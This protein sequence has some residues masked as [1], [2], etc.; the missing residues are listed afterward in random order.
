MMIAIK[1]GT[2]H[3]HHYIISQDVNSPILPF[4]F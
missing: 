4:A 2:G 3:F 1:K